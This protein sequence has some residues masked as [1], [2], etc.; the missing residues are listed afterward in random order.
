DRTTHHKGPVR[1]LTAVELSRVDAGYRF[2]A[3]TDF[4]FRGQGIGVPR[5][6]DVLMKHGAAR[7]IIEMKGGT[8][9]LAQAVGA[10]VR[11][12][13]AG[14]RVCVGSFHQ[15][16]IDAMRAGFPEIVTS[17]SQEE[18]RWTLHRAWVRW[19]W[20]SERPYVAFQV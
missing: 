5:L 1:E 16:S 8:P 17:A 7:V 13:S 15:S 4:P 12:A 20:T 10:S 9:E 19:P 18:A 6:D 11:K 2:Q 3:D 14:D